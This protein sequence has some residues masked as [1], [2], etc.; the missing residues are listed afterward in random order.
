M[1]KDNLVF[2]LV[3]VIVGIIVGVLIANSSFPRQGTPPLPAQ[4][5]ASPGPTQ[6]STQ[7]PEGGQLPDGHPAIDEGALKQQIVAQQE[8]LKKDPQ[9]QQA[10]ISIANLNFDLKSYEEAAK[11][12]EK[13]L[14]KDPKNVN[15]ITDLGTSYLWLNQPQKALEFYDKSLSL[16]PN[17]FQTLLNLGIARMSMGNRPGAAEA[18]EKLVTLYPD[19]PEAGMLRDA[20]KKLR[21]KKEGS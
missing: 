10:I 17:H 15:L 16:D 2:G 5:A 1:T 11:W 9:N 19:H 8:I 6:S 12:Y 3:G 14:A 4:M 18:W 21:S 20:I 7:P 13:A